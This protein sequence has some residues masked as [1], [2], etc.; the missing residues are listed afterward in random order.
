MLK[1]EVVVEKEDKEKLVA[2]ISEMDSILSKYPYMSCFDST[3]TNIS[4]AK[5]FTKDAKKWIEL[6]ETNEE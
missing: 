6:L 3:I 1:N 5:S 2:L 4:R